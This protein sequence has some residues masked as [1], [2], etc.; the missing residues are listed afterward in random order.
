MI[1]RFV[2]IDW[3]ST[4]SWVD[5][6]ASVGTVL[7]VVVALIFGVGE[8][9]RLR[10]EQS[11][12]DQ[13]LQREQATRVAAWV[14]IREPMDSPYR[15]VEAIPFVLNASDRP[16]YDVTVTVE[17]VRSHGEA[18]PVQWAVGMLP[19]NTQRHSQQVETLHGEDGPVACSFRDIDGRWWLHTEAGYVLPLPGNPHEDD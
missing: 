12:R 6:L 10:R 18:E 8:V 4:V 19:P 15:G 11:D 9:R 2:S 17:V 3:S 7:A 14:E 16:V 13:A 1:T 5:V